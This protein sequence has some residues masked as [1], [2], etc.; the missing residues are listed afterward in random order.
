MRKLASLKSEIDVWDSICNR[1][2]DLLEL[3]DLAIDE[4]DESLFETLVSDADALDD[5]IRS[6]QFRLNF[7]GENDDRPAI[8]SVKQ[9]AGGIEAQDWSEMLF[10]MYRQWGE[11]S[12]YEVDVLDFTPGDVAGIKSASV[13]LEGEHAYGY[14]KS[15]R[16]AHRLQRVSPYGSNGKR[17]TSFSLV[18]VYPEMDYA[19]SAELDLSEVKE[20]HIRARGNGG[21]NV[22]KNLTAIRL[23]HEPTG[24]TVSVQNERSQSQNRQIAIRILQARLDDVERRR[25]AEKQ[26]EL[27][28]EHV[29]AEFG[30]QVRTYVL[31]PYQMVKDHRTGHEV[32]DFSGVLAGDLDGFLQ[33]SLESEIVG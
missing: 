32:N 25:K 7:G 24:I 10:A 33:S 18:E 21:Q 11:R 6:H 2:D 30:R 22:N 26:A 29:S 8:V 31:H 19:E 17:H 4:S 5:E 23:K 13:K 12:G 9:G 15:E 3:A 27:K 16:G 20:E 14:L 1:C 28:G